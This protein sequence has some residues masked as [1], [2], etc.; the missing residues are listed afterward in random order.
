[1]TSSFISSEKDHKLY[2]SIRAPTA[3]TNWVFRAILRI[4]SLV[5]SYSFPR[6]HSICCQK[7]QASVWP[8]LKVH[9]LHHSR[10]WAI[11]SSSGFRISVQNHRRGHEQIARPMKRINSRSTWTT[12]NNAA[13]FKRIMCYCFLIL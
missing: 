3:A 7:C 4:F 1:M 10:T 13:Q 9:W 6:S 8:T 12:D 2:Y 5:D 11:G